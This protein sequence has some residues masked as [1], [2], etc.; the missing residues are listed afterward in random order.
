LAVARP[1]A[2][3]FVAAFAPAWVRGLVLRELLVARVLT[4]ALALAGLLA[5]ELLCARE[6]FDAEPEVLRADVV[7]AFCAG[8]LRRGVRR[9]AE[10]ISARATA[11][12]CVLIS[13]SRKLSM[14][15]SSRRI[16]RAS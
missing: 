16:D 12:V 6:L 10:G 13:C 14:R 8:P 11:L 1:A 15:S 3:R 4:L 2:E 7:R 9:S 5:V